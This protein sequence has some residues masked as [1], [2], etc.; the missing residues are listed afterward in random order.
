MA[1]STLVVFDDAVYLRALL[2][3]CAKAFFGAEEGSRVAR[4]IDSESY[5][6]CKILPPEGGKLTAETV[7]ALPAESMLRPAEGKN[8]LYVLS[9]FESVTPLVQ[10]KLLKLLEEPLR[11]SPFCGGRDRRGAR[12][13]LCGQG[14]DSRR[15]A[16]L[17]RDLFGGGNA[18]GGRG[19]SCSCRGVFVGRADGGDLP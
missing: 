12:T 2:K 4:L 10:N 3:E 15:S 1:Q 5:L 17:R 6:D 13:Q 16:R 18:A 7:S 19:R 8:K 11:R 9:S 14:G